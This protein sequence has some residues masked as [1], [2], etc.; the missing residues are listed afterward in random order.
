MRDDR[1]SLYSEWQGEIE[2]RERARSLRRNA[3]DAERLLWRHLRKRQLS[4][5]R[6]RRQQPVGPYIVDFLCFERR[7]IVE[8]DGGQHAESRYDSERTEWLESKGF[9]VLRFWNTEVLGN[10]EGVGH[11]IVEAL[12]GEGSEPPSLRQAQ[13]RL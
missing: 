8:V 5:Y 12:N 2:S 7:L 1:Q 4:G 9:R 6:F 10:M 11:E 3:T 13:G